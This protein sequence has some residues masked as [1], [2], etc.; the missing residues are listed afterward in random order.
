MLIQIISSYFCCGIIIEN[1]IVIKSAPI[2]SYMI[3]WN[4]KRFKEY[5]DKKKFEY[6]VLNLDV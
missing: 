6:K 4:G 3:G 2:V 1:G 5:C